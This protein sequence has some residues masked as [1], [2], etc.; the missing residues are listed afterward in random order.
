MP[1]Y[2]KM[3]K[4]FLD[5]LQGVSYIGKPKNHTM[6]YLTKKIEEKIS[7]LANVCD[8]LVFVED[9]VF[10]PP[11]IEQKN[12]LIACKD[13]ASSYTEVA[14]LLEQKILE[15]NK[16]KSY[17]FTDQGFVIGE[18]VVLGNNVL[19]EPGAFL[20]HNVRIGNNVLIKTGAKIRKNTC[21]G[22]DCII[23][24]NTV[25]GD[26]PFNTTTLSD[27]RFVVIPSFG[28]TIIGNNVFIGACV[29]IS[30]G[31]ADNTIVEDDVKIDANVRLGHD[32]HLHR[33]VEIMG[34]AG[35]GGYTEVGEFTIVASDASLKNRINIGKHCF[36]SMSS[37]VY[38]DLRDNVTVIGNP[39]ITM[40]QAAK[41]KIVKM[42][43][44]RL[45]KK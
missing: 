32:V 5:S 33:N 18:G 21:I 9:T 10:V 17:K 25:I 45:L 31:S 27:G 26:T 20:D 30:K 36:I 28:G 16:K 24:E 44:K 42:K 11:E 1:T 2:V 12:I 29:T 19:I 6:L 3:E 14:F 35:I 38:H 13:P 40:E 15:E 23:G 22:N 37:V 39:A 41:D 43:L 8:C 7:C 34:R 4:D